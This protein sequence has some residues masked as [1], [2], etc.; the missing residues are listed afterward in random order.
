MNRWQQVNETEV[1]LM[2]NPS[3]EVWFCASPQGNKGPFTREQ[4]LDLLKRGVININSYIWRESYRNWVKVIDSGDFVEPQQD[5]AQQV[6]APPETGPVAP[7]GDIVPPDSAAQDDYL[8]GVF[9]N[10][11]K[12]SW[13]RYRKKITSQEVDEVLVGGVITATLDNGYSLI[14]LESTGTDHFLRFEEISSGN[15]MIFQLRHLA[16][17]FMTS[18]V[19]GHE[20]SVTL[21]YGERFQNFAAVWKALRQEMKGGYIRSPDPGIITVDG[22]MSSQYI[23]VEVGLLW[24][25]NDYLAPDNPY[26]VLY[27]KLT[28]HIGATIHALRKY[29][30]GRF[31]GL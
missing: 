26:D 4:M 14:D 13:T 29:L 2:T 20:A 24:D 9:V 27:P 15:R 19:I 5:A 7:A 22:D 17:S 31:A 10:L 1:N 18:Q 8:D 6:A 11:V 25:I 12:D 3:Q 28:S 23:Y 16:E 21:G 30:R